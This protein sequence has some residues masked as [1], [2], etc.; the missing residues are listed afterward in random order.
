MTKHTLFLVHGMGAHEGT[1]WSDEIWNKLVECSERY[2]HFRTKKKLEEYAEPAPVQYDQFI[3][4]A[5]ARWDAQATTF[6][7]F[8]QANEL[9]HGN[10][11]D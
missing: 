10:S 6:G 1:Q 2:P 9:R 11:L 8:A 4:A 5:L 7:E 3:R